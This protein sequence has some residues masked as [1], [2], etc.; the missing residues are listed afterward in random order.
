MADVKWHYFKHNVEQIISCMAES[1]TEA[2]EFIASGDY[3]TDAT[4]PSRNLTFVRVAPPSTDA[5]DATREQFR[6]ELRA[7]VNPSA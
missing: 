6:E 2:R 1:E 3:D 5:T 7:M 4:G